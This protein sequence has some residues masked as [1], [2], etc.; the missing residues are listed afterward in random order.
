MNTFF[1]IEKIYWKLKEPIEIGFPR[2]NKLA[3]IAKH[4]L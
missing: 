4:D 1:K 3:Y 2:A